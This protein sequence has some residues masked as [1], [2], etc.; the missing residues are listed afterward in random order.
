MMVRKGAAVLLAL[1]LILGAVS[2]S[3]CQNAEQP[4]QDKE[5]CVHSFSNGYC[6]KCGK[7]SES[8]VTDDTADD[9]DTPEK[10]PTPEVD[11][12][13]SEGVE[14]ID[15]NGIRYVYKGDKTCI[16]AGLAENAKPEE[17]VIP[18]KNDNG[19]TVTAIGDGA[20]EN[21]FTLTAISL[22][23]GITAIGGEA[24]R[25]CSSLKSIVLPNGVVKLGEGVFEGCLKLANVTFSEQ[26]VSVPARCFRNC[27]KLET[28]TL[29]NGISYIGEEAFRNCE[30]LKEVQMTGVSYVGGSAFER[31]ANLQEV[32]FPSSLKKVDT[33]AFLNCPRLQKAVFESGKAGQNDKESGVTIGEAVFQN[34][35]AL[36]DV[37][38]SEQTQVIGASAFEGCVALQRVSLPD[39][40]LEIGEAAYK[41]CEK[42]QSLT[43]GNNAGLRVIRDSAFANCTSLTSVQFPH[44]LTAIDSSAFFSCS[45]LKEVTFPAT[46]GTFSIGSHAFNNCVGLTRLL[47]DNNKTEI[48][49]SAFEGC[50]ELGAVDLKSS[51]VTIGDKA[52]SSCAKLSGVYVQGG[53]ILGADVFLHTPLP[54]TKYANGSY[55]GTK[56]N[57]YMLLIGY[58]APSSSSQLNVTIHAKTSAIT[59]NAFRY[60]AEDS[61]FTEVYIPAGVR[62]L[63]DEA[64]SGCLYLQKVMFAEGSE[65][66]SIGTKAFYQCNALH[67][68]RLPASLTE[69]K[70]EAFAGCMELSAIDFPAKLTELG[71]GAF[72]DCMA[73]SKITFPVDS[74]L[75]AL[76]P[77][78]FARCVSLAEIT[79]P[80]SVEV[81][82]DGAFS[83][84]S[85]LRNVILQDAAAIREISL[86]SFES[87]SNL[88]FNK[89]GNGLYL[90]NQ[91]HP[92]M[93]LLSAENR[94]TT[95]LTLHA[96]T[97]LVADD[98]LKDCSGLKI[99]SIPSESALGRI[100]NGALYGCSSLTELYIP[101]DLESI[102]EE[103]LRGCGA[104]EN[105][106]VSAG[107]GRYISDGKCLIDVE[108]K[109]LLRGCAD[110]RIPEDSRVEVIGAY[111]FEGC[112]DLLEL[113]IPRTICRIDANAFAH[114][115]IRLIL[116]CGETALWEQMELDKD[117]RADAVNLGQVVCL[118]KCLEIAANG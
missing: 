27:V 65:L 64:F 21:C 66:V 56:E 106:F 41:N 4:N 113:E 34:C 78:V 72:E 32:V 10:D 59:G 33:R 23:S 102:G 25:N 94:M 55:L 92:Y 81:L 73:L 45:S 85:Q 101:A 43:F 110:S 7:K 31:C 53:L 74:T 82:C 44:S 99:L 15:E 36:A 103:A 77:S 90:G 62:S 52:F 5:D 67:E 95:E 11:T 97:V 104:L 111:A 14:T 42:L 105:I 37:T 86:E 51:L 16:V 117:W 89:Y 46:E 98:A 8:V 100:G 49:T 61:R 20:F 84:C 35:R 60:I 26:L 70:A 107:N 1:S 22:P 47:F 88:F 114:S 9:P 58:E 29:H 109:T 2:L 13:V 69:I 75:T 79:L 48:G 68:L 71:D 80:A 3:G 115:G 38:L 116:F 112:S 83:G 93:I 12:D 63:G 76:N 19:D 24:F 18:E 28:I 30:A 87:C 17:L 118:D 96:D 108:T 91:N 50:S 54:V 40:L 6:T 39:S 57:P